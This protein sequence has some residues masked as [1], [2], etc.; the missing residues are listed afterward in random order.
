M[1]LRFVSAGVQ[2]SGYGIGRAQTEWRDTNGTRV[3]V[4]R[5]FRRDESVG[6]SDG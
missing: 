6:M 3:V 4:Q 5:Y 2:E 1:S